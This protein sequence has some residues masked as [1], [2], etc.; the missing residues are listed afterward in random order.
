MLPKRAE[1]N[2]VQKDIANL[3]PSPPLFKNRTK[4]T[5][6]REKLTQPKML[7]FIQ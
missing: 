3:P 7:Y 4:L 5:T 1:D 6:K 2:N